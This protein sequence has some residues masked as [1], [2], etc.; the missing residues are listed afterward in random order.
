MHNQN[1]NTIGYDGLGYVT[2]DLKVV[3]VS[4]EPGS[5][6][7][8]PAIETVNSGEYPIARDLYMY[9]AGEPEGATKIYLDWVYSP[10]A[11]KIVKDLGFVPVE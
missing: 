2:E 6:Y 4:E 5:P 1:P 11:Q 10:E 7:I 3:A 8:F 9:T